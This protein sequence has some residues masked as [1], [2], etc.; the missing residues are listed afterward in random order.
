MSPD[1]VNEVALGY[2]D[3]ISVVILLLGSPHLFMQ[4]GGVEELWGQYGASG[5]YSV[6]NVQKQTLVIV[7]H[8]GDG[9]ASVA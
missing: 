6:Y 3:I 7:V 1:D 4:M 5:F 9:C 8:E 2:Y